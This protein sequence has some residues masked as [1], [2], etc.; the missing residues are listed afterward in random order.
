M[1]DQK[2]LVLVTGSSGLIGSAV[3]ERL[4]QKYLVVGMDR[5]GLPQAP[6]E[7]TRIDVDLSQDQ[8]VRDAL[9]RLREVHGT[10]VASVVHLAAYYDFAGEPSP[11][12]EQVTVRGTQRLLTGMRDAFEVEQFIFSSTLLV[13]APCE[14]GQTINEEWPLEPKWEYPQSKVRT[15]ELMRREHGNVPIVMLRVAGVYTDRCN[16]IPIAHQIQRLYEK[17]MVARVFPGSTSHGQPWVHLDDVV[18]AIWLTVEKRQQLG[19][20]LVL[21]IGEDR[22]YSYDE[23]Q[24]TIARLIHG[25][26][27][28]TTQI[29]KAVAKTGAWLQD[30]IPGED[31][32]IKPWMID[33]ADDHYELDITRARQTIGWQPKH[34]LRATLPKMIQFLQNDPHEFYSA[35]KL[36]LPSDLQKQEAKGV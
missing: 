15:E 32:F 21:L 25:E 5:P 12:Y 18:E 10:R 2:P 19:S 36:D 9:A 16:S 28:E 26:S 14:P 35:N 17:K 22:T 24:H 7:A 8:S 6:G 31:P 3:C 23:L 4:S 34:T 13:H 27:F 11:L 33:M 29:P 20:E 30:K 1:A